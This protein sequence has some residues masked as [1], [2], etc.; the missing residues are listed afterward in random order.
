MAFGNLI[1]WFIPGKVQGNTEL[2]WRTRFLSQTILI[3]LLISATMA[4]LYTALGNTTLTAETASVC[5]TLL[6]CLLALRL[7]VGVSAITHVA[8]S[9]FGITVT[10]GSLLEDHFDGAALAWFG[11][12]PFLA[13][14]MIGRRAALT[15]AVIAVGCMVVLFLKLDS[16]TDGTPLQRT[17]AL[18]RS[19][20]LMCTVLAFALS[21]R[22]WHEEARL[23]LERANQAKS[24]FLANMSH[25]LRTPMNGVLGMVEVILQKPLSPE[26]IEELEVIRHSGRAMVE[27][28]NGILDLSK[29]EAG[30]MALD[31]RGFS[32]I[33]LMDDLAHLYRP[34]AA[35]RGLSFSIDRVG[36]LGH[37]SGDEHRLRQVLTNLL[38]NALK[39]TSSG[40]VRVLTRRMGEVVHFEVKDTGLGIAPDVAKRLFNPFE[41]ADSSTTRRFGGSGLGLALSRQLVE[42]MHGELQLE[43]TPGHGSSFSFALPL[44]VVAAPRTE[45]TPVAVAPVAHGRVLVVD[46][47]PINLRVASALVASAGY[48]VGQASNGILALERLDQERWDVVLMDCHMPEM[49]GY[50]A[51]RR[52]RARGCTI[53]VIALT[54]AAMAEELDACLAAGMNDCLTKPV[55]LPS[56]KRVLGQAVASSQTQV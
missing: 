17:F 29:I 35:N 37:V 49:D 3:G 10:I 13:A 27:Q 18:I 39:F 44:P 50:E 46:D 52:L 7:G 40:S 32:L 36:A 53:P 30:K 11:V 25:E 31:A 4:V 42:L 55:D 45:R 24:R 54:A 21:F 14:V 5:A 19:V 9:L 38:D 2:A 28:I 23:R 47:N 22:G 6:A 15:W 33:A 56:L 8:L 16:P 20:G 12:I 1:E 26:L 43:S 34:Q 51:T 41:Q 48:E